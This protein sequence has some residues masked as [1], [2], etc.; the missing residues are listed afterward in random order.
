[1]KGLEE[2]GY[3]H[4]CT[5]G[6]A[7]PWMFQDTI[8]FIAGINRIGICIVMTGAVVIAYTLMDNHVHFVLYGTLPQCKGFINLYKRLTGKWIRTRYGH[9]DFLHNLPVEIIRIEGEESLLNTIAYLDRNP[10]VAGFK[11]MPGEYPWGSARYMFKAEGTGMENYRSMES[12]TRREQKALLHSHTVLPQDWNVDCNGMILPTSFMNIRRLESFFRS[13]ARYSYF[14]AKKLEGIVEQNLEHS[15]KSF[16]P[17]KELRPVVRQLAL[18]KYGSDDIKGL[19]V[20]ARLSIARILRYSY[21]STLKQISR[22]IHIDTGTLEGF[23]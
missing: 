9:G 23:V 15:R 19:N 20:N 17:D 7:I 18:E 10:I 13:P 14:L 1:M 4:I 6:K 16:I 3:F 2:T 8:D 11:Y 5:D 21:G 12:F 22:M